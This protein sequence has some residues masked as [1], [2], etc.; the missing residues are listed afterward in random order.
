MTSLA[1]HNYNTNKRL[2]PT[3]DYTHAI[4]AAW[5]V[6]EEKQF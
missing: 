3:E 2:K 6:I 1:V 4:C 5:E